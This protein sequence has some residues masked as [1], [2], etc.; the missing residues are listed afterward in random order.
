MTTK[1][2]CRV[3]G[4][5]HAVRVDGVTTPVRP[6]VQAPRR[7]PAKPADDAAVVEMRQRLE[8]ERAGLDQARRALASGAA[9]L[10]QMESDLVRQ[11]E[12][13]V[14]ELALEIA[15]KVLMQ[16]I[17][18]DRYEID[19][20]VKEALRHAPTRREVVVRLHPDDLARCGQ[21]SSPPAES[22]DVQ[23]VADPSVPRAGCVVETPEGV[24]ESALDAHLATLGEA[25][26]GLE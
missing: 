4:R 23:L 10:A 13:Q 15:A 1:A 11:A 20:I 14:L 8:A 24:V 26:R 6:D 2:T 19:P 22:G 12:G 25:L 16:E 18:A 3:S 17:R 9:Q 5:I 21:G 7:P